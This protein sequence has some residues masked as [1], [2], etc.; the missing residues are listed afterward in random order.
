[1]TNTKNITARRQCLKIAAI[2]AFAWAQDSASETFND[3]VRDL[4]GDAPTGE[5]YADALR[6]FDSGFG[7]LSE[8]PATSS[9]VSSRWADLYNREVER[10]Y[11]REIRRR[12][13]NALAD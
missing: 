8:S 2:D 4:N 7:G 10:A 1:M 13:A 9:R 12:I 6:G 11:R 5:V 3:L